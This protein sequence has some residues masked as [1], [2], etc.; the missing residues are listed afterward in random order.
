MKTKLNGFLTLFLALLVQISFAQERMV[1]GVVSDNSGMPIPGV[2]VIIK[3]TT[4]GTQTDFDGKFSIKAA[5][6]QTL[7]FSYVGMTRKEVVASSA[8]LNVTMADNSIELEGVIVTALGIKRDKKALG[9]A[10]TTIGKEDITNVVTNNPLESLSGKVAGV[11]ISAPTQPGAST[12]VIVRGIG[13]ISGSNQPLYVVDGTP[14]NNSASG[15]TSTSRSFDAG[16]G[17]ND[18]DPNSIE[19]ITFLKGSAATALYGSRA[20]RGAVIIT[21]KKGKNTSKINIDFTSSLDVN[22][23]ARVPHLQNQFGQGWNGQGFSQLSTGVGPSNENGSWGPSFN[24]EIRP[25]GTVYDNSQQ[26]KPY[27]ALENN[28]RDFYERGLTNT[29]SINISGG[30]D[31]SDFSLGFTNMNSDGVIPTTAD[32]FVKRSFTFNGGIKN[33]KTAIRTN[34]NFTNKDQNAVNTGQGDA[35]GEGATLMQELLQ[36]PRDLSIIGFA[37]YKNNPFNSP[38]YYFTPYSANPYSTVS[39]NS[40]KILGNNLFGNVNIS[41]KITDNLSA[42]WQV[43]G[44][45]RVENIKSYGAIVNYLPGSPQDAAATLPVVGGVT[46]G[47][48]ERSEFDTYFNLNYDKTLSESFR[49]NLLAGVSY[50]QREGNS[51]SASVTAL[52]VPNFYELSNSANRPEITQNNTLRRTFGYYGQ[53]ELSFKDKLFLT[54]SGRNDKTSTLPSKNNSYFY[55]AA[56]VSGIVID[57][58]RNFLKL[59]GAVSQVAND[60]DPYQTESSLVTGNAAANFG[61]ISSPFGGINFYELAGVLGNINLKPERTTEYEVGLE[62]SLFSRKVTFDI[63]YYNRKTTDLIVA[64]PLDPSTG[65]SSQA[66]NIGDVVNKGIEVAIGLT[67]FKTDNFSWNLNYTFAKNDNE[68][69]KVNGGTRIDITSAYG[70]SFSA[71]EG[72]PIGSFFAKVPVVNADGQYVVNPDTGYYTVTDDLEYVGDGQRDF[73]MGLQNILKYKNVSMSFAFDW[74]QGGKMYSYTKRLSHFVGNGIETTYNDRNTFIIPN[75]VNE[76]TDGTGAVTGYTENTTP[77]SFENITNFWGNT[78]N[79]PGVEKDHLIDK[80]FV[81]LRDISMYYDF[82]SKVAEK[83]G[84]SKL[85]VGVY[86]RN[87]F[88]W[89]PAENPYIDPEVTSYGNDLLSEFGEFGANPSQRV[90]GGSIKL[91]F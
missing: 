21:T 85:S 41:H 32:A 50:N 45:Y 84:L 72:L 36:I 48:I 81:R 35:A 60:T 67:P 37:D 7:V 39:E 63:S 59:R 54:L 13:S 75:S 33:E 69:T 29:N 65:Y 24:G 71:E 40:T 68:V 70:I 51:L 62:G 26:I 28:V 44:N 34:I 83:L 23:V 46:E 79:N 42:S 20:G 56:S 1:S 5:P 80:S 88:M 87:L 16:T 4:S 27:V 3:G 30:N 66:S 73:I 76:V 55:P 52:D 31:F 49:L 43:G 89:T 10:A 78:S 77:I 14:I 18:L 57:N 38:S 8:T 19:K 6:S 9:Y 25:W 22:E 64:V 12:K 47:R 53:A 82:S 90:F 15:S 74:K 91:S 86:G 17:L 11:D 2:N 58:G 61:V